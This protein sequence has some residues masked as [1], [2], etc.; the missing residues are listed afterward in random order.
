M[1]G[2]QD[3]RRASTSSRRGV[4]GK[5]ENEGKKEMVWLGKKCI[6]ADCGANHMGCILEDGKVYTWG[7]SNKGQLGHEH[8]DSELSPLRHERKDT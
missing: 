6:Y 4:K 8:L 2:G 3:D 7:S 1:A 5:V